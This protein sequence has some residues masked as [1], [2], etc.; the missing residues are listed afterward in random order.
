[1]KVSVRKNALL[2]GPIRYEAWLPGFGIFVGVGPTPESAVTDLTKQAVNFIARAKPSTA[3]KFLEKA[4]LVRTV[5]Q[6]E[7]RLIDC[8]VV[9]NVD[10]DEMLTETF[11]R[12]RSPSRALL[13]SHS[14]PR[15]NR[16][17]SL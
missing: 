13:N 6:L 14:L 16:S 3:K 11:L 5:A 4:H 10:I 15:A 1:M 2:D 8:S 9:D 17:I 7:W 12:T